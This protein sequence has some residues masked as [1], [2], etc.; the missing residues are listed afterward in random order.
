MKTFISSL[1]VGCALFVSTG[2]K[3]QVKSP[4]SFGVKAGISLSTTN[5][6]DYEMKPGFVGGIV[7][8]YEL[9]RNLFLR[10]GIDFVM[11]GAKLDKERVSNTNSV[12]GVSPRYQ[13][14][15]RVRLNYLQMPVTFG[16]KYQVGNGFT[17]YLNAGP[18]VG[19]GVYG[20]GRSSVRLVSGDRPAGGLV[21]GC[22]E[23]DSFDDLA[24]KKFDFGITG[25]IGAEYKQY[26]VNVGYEYGLTNLAK[27]D[28]NTSWH[29]MIAT[30]ALGYK[31]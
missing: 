9:S 27:D 19:F 2:S 28:R 25:S 7:V 22:I 12:I 17:A 16:Y 6:D 23:S 1:L 10:S 18:Y 21:D 24:L 30:C 29:N 15:D 31:F 5:E 13:F 14:E 8:D 3:A 4:L 20:R 26:F 11:K